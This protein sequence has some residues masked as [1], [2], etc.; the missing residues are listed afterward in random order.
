MTKEVDL[1][2]QRKVEASV[3]ID[4]SLLATKAKQ[5]EQIAQLVDLISNTTGLNLEATQLLIKG[6]LDLIKAKTDNLDVALSSRS[7]EATLLTRLSKADFE[8]R[9]NTL[10]QK[11]MAL[12]TP[13]A[14]A[15]D[16]AAIPVTIPS[17]PSNGIKFGD[18]A[19]VV[20]VA[21]STSTQ[22][23]KVANTSRKEII[24]HNDTNK[25]LWISY[26]SP[27]A[28]NKG[29]LLTKNSTIFEENY[30][31]AIY[32]ISEAAVSGNLQVTEVTT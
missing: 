2:K 20:T 17:L 12:S 31:G 13:V 32:G 30:R 3:T 6:V 14:I 29:Y 27:A 10:G 11:T 4:T 5:D 21:A 8:A 7:T 18:S 28:L 1:R 24:I 15:S 23:L 19:T 9:I 22:V 26:A 25:N 16:Q